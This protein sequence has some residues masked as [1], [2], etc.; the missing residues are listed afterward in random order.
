[1]DILNLTSRFSVGGNFIHRNH[2]SSTSV[3]SHPSLFSGFIVRSSLPFPEEKAKYHRELKSAV[4]VVER[5]CH[6]CVDVQKSLFSSGGILEKND[7]TPVTVADFG[8]QALISLG[9]LFPSIPLVAEEDSAFLRANNLGNS[10][11]NVVSDKTIIKD[12]TESDVLEAID[13]GG[14]DAFVFGTKPATYWVLDPIDGTKGFVMGGDALY[15]VGLALVVDGEVVGGIM[16]CPNWQDENISN[17]ETGL[18]SERGIVMV[19]HVGC[20]TWRK[21][22]FGMGRSAT[23]APSYWSRC[24]VDKYSLIH[25]AHFCT[26]DN[27]TW[28]SLP[29]TASLDATTNPESTNENKVLFLTACCGSLFKYL[30]VASGRAT[31]FIMRAR[32]QVVIKSW[33]H[34]VGM[35][36]VHEAGGKVTDWRGGQIDLAADEVERRILYPGGGFLATNGLLHSEVLQMIS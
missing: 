31:V 30:M 9:K 22:L 7:N 17:S 28:E 6:L 13:R 14:K 36:C 11:M 34:A 27:Q 1:M 32:A 24:Y 12:L 29:L 26:S 4:D 23:E 16:G 33:D 15:V 20:G 2:I 19:A 35:I 3:R 5:A 21:K 8:V 10:V 25:Q 18:L